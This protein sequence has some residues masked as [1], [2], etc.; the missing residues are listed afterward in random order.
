MRPS[1]L[2]SILPL[3]AAYNSSSRCS[4]NQNNATAPEEC[5]CLTYKAACTMNIERMF[6][7]KIFYNRKQGIT[8]EQFNDYWANSHRALATPFHLRLGVVKY[9]QYHSTPDF[10][11]LGRVEGALPILEFD[12]AAE[13]WVH[14]LETFQAMGSDPEYI[15]KIQPDEANFIDLA[16][17]RMII[18]VDY[19][20][21]E[22]QN[23]VK[24]HGRSF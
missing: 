20:V 22:S 10:R 3:A 13:F 5:C 7:I 11:D 21:V 12:G 16:S 6:H 24:E 23:E 14:N 2:L 8:P 4:N 1:T 15:N 9:S 18:G 19:I 17:M